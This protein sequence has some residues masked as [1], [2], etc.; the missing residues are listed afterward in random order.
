M[1]WKKYEDVISEEEYEEL[2][3]EAHSNKI[4]LEIRIP[5]WLTL[6]LFVVLFFC[7]IGSSKPIGEHDIV[8]ILGSFGL[9]IPFW[10]WGLYKGF[11]KLDAYTDFTI[12]CIARARRGEE[13]AAEINGQV[14]FD[15]RPGGA[16]YGTARRLLT[17]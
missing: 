2:V 4:G 16:E 9:T 11:H 7:W 10:I 6:A 17:K 14:I 12:D 13:F 5:L 15:T 3:Q 8:L 1:K